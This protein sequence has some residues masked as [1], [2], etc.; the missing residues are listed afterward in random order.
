MTDPFAEKIGINEQGGSVNVQNLNL[1]I[2]ERLGQV[3]DRVRILVVAA[4][5]SNS[6]FETNFECCSA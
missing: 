3:G 5:P 4:N 6:H 1:G 2:A